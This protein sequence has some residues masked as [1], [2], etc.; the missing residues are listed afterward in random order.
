MMNED[1]PVQ[2]GYLPTH[3]NRRTLCALA[4]PEVLFELC[5]GSWR[6]CH[7]VMTISWFPKRI[8]ICGKSNNKP[9]IL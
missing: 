2:A 8:Y 6:S 9:P 4:K 3:A 1:K 7:L 5:C